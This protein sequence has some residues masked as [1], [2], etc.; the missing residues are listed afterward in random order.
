MLCRNICLRVTAM[1]TRLL[2]AA[3]LAWIIS[4]HL[5]AQVVIQPKCGTPGPCLTPIPQP[6]IIPIVEPQT[7]LTPASPP[8]PLIQKDVTLSQGQMLHVFGRLEFTGNVGTTQG[9]AGGI[10]YVDAYLDCNDPN[11]N[12][13]TGQQ[14]IG[15][16]FLGPNQSPGPSYPT[17]GHMALL[18]F[19]ADYGSHSRDVFLS[20]AVSRG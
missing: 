8:T 3:L 10:D 19:D 11:G 15:Q 4:T 17:T 1:K 2:G 12:L 7:N 13:V 20:A 5:A 16:N 9:G 14:D 18:P 6:T